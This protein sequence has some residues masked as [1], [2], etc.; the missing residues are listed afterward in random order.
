MEALKYDS[1]I[2]M[3]WF[4]QHFIEANPSIFQLILMKSFTSKELLPNF[5]NDTRIERESQIKL[6]GKTIDDELKFGKHIDILCKNAA[7]HKGKRS[8]S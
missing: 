6:L 3:E 1:K 2:A 4:H 7:R 8:N 5:I